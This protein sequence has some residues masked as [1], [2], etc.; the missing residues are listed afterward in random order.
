MEPCSFRRKCVE[1]RVYELLI[2]VKNSE[3]REQRDEVSFFQKNK[4]I[5][6]CLLMHH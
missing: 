6:M 4:S 2:T 5:K 1:I 3:L